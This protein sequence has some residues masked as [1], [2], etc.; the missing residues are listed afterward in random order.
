MH[1]NFLVIII[2]MDG[3]LWGYTEV[4]E[5]FNPE[6]GFLVRSSFKKT[7]F[8]ILRQWNQKTLSNS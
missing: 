3:T 4:G 1:L 7:E 8:R 6:V 5:G 2:G